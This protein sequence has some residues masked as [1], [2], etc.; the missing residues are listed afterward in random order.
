MADDSEKTV[1]VIVALH[2]LAVPCLEKRDAVPMSTCNG[3]D[4]T[5]FSARTSCHRPA[6]K[7]EPCSS[8]AAN[9]CT[10][11][12]ADTIIVCTAPAPIVAKH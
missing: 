9:D 10:A 6:P 12:H 5:T 4:R 1:A 7:T 8:R 2:G 3:S 11:R